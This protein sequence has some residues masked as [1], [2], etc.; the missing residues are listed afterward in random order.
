MASPTLLLHKI[1]IENLWILFVNVVWSGSSFLS[2]R[3]AQGY[4]PLHLAAKIGRIDM[5]RELIRV[6]VSLNPR[7]SK[8]M[9]TPLALAAENGHTKIVEI[10]L[11][12]GADGCISTL[13]GKLPIHLAVIKGHLD[14]VKVLVE[15]DESNIHYITT[16][17]YSKTP[18]HLCAEFDQLEIAKFLLEKGANKY[19][20][21]KISYTPIH[22]AKEYGRLE[23]IKL[24]IGETYLDSVD[25][26]YS[27]IHTNHEHIIKHYIDAGS[28]IFEEYG[29]NILNSALS[30][31]NLVIIKLLIDEAGIDINTVLDN[32][33]EKPIHRV[34][35]S[36]VRPNLELIKLLIELGAD[37]EAT[38]SNKELTSLHYA[39]MNG[40]LEVVKYLIEEV[41]V[42]ADPYDKYQKTPLD[43]ARENDR[44]QVVDYL[45]LLYDT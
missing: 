10:L 9:K 22:A 18:L 3:S 1:I 27:A 23:L 5:V 11:R 37:P 12:A 45:E 24:F 33:G 39:A 41:G 2:Y 30:L 31:E 35:S 25:V 13:R 44:T 26:I 42:I 20:P 19:A 43:C 7:T 28:S 15:H 4:T 40:H 38:T 36:F 8:W 16:G 14:T 21:T 32:Y 29:K 6:G 34:T 17:L